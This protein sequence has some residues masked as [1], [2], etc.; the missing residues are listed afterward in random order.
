MTKTVPRPR[1]HLAIAAAIVLLM[2][3][4]ALAQAQG[5]HAVAPGA[6]LAD[7]IAAG[8]DGNVWYTEFH[9]RRIG[10]VTPTGKIRRFGV[11][12]RGPA[13]IAAGPDGAL[14]FT[15]FGDRIGRITT[16]GKI[17]EL[18]VPFGNYRGITAGPDGRLWFVD[19]DGDKVVAMTTAGVVSV[20]PLPMG[21]TPQEIVTGPDR[22]LWVT[23]HSRQAIARI[24]PA[25]QVTEF[26]LPS[27]GGNPA[28]ITVGPDG[29]LWFTGE[30]HRR[31]RG[32]ITRPARRDRVSVPEF[33][34]R[35][36]HR[37]RHHL[38]MA[39]P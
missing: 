33:P 36:L 4:P 28:G 34:A 19:K 16:A 24:T 37:G 15:E 29:A 1:V 14:W 38:R 35:F 17:T 3:I 31:P 7:G 11:T 21:S 5:T 26:P 30:H 32:C 23:L 13:A 8:P 18:P 39:C 2:C 27:G 25:G 12:T 6:A 20:V 10:R 9:S 22:N